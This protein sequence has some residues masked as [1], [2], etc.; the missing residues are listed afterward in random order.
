[1]A[2]TGSFA[3]ALSRLHLSQPAASRQIHALESEL[4]VA[5]FDRV[6]RGMQ[7]TP[8]G[9]DLLRHSRVVLSGADGLHQRARALKSGN[10]GLV[11]LG[12]TPQVI[13]NLLAAF[14]PRYAKDFPLVEVELVEDGGARLPTRL[15]RGDVH[16]A[17]MPTGDE[18]F[19][20]R[21][22]YPMHVFVAMSKTHRLSRRAVIDVKELAQ[23]RLMVGSGFASRTWFEAACHLA[24]V[25]PRIVLESAAPHTLVALAKVGYGV[26][27][28]PSPAS[29]TGDHVCTAPL[30]HRGA[31]IGRWARVAWNPERV[32]APFAQ[33]FVSALVDFCA[34]NFPGRTLVRRAPAL[35]RPK[36]NV[37]ADRVADLPD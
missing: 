37:R 35:Q 32:L 9:E 13:E 21:L 36:E 23:E 19:D 16:L 12:A 11:K 34:K 8:E 30:V 4:G 6:A 26:A 7:L 1:V 24:H 31:S 5:L 33:R 18:R 10:T 20:G 25:A 14:L 15:G 29:I 27:I 2:D 22:L 28:L 17:V 3:Q